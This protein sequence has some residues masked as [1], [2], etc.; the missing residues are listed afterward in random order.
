MLADYP[1]IKASHI[2]TDNDVV[3]NE[4]CFG[5]CFNW[6]WQTVQLDAS[7]EYKRL[8]RHPDFPHSTDEWNPIWLAV[9]DDHDYGKDNSDASNPRKLENKRAFIEFYKRLNHRHSWIQS[10]AEIANMTKYKNRGIYHHFRHTQAIT[11]GVVAV[12]FVLL[13]VRYYR[14]KDDMLGAA[15]WRWLHELMIK[16]HQNKPNWLV[17]VLGTTF[18]VKHPRMAKKAGA[19][20]WDIESKLRLKRLMILSNVQRQ[21]ILLLSGDVHYSVV[22]DLNGL[23]EFTVSS[24]THSLG[25]VQKCC[26]TQEHKHAVTPVQCVDG[27]GLLKFT[28]NTWEFK[29]RDSNQKAYIPCRG[30][31]MK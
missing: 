8:L 31:E 22:Y 4:Q 27:Y 5:N 29:L 16:I 15:Q 9:W 25:C 13:D 1:C 20:Y 3:D 12:D 28:Q 23:K 24:F 11:E 30:E 2:T 19:E 18:L 10:H 6:F 26:G 17:F 7:T 14:K 21:R